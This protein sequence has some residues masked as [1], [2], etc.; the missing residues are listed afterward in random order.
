[1]WSNKYIGI[2]YKQKGRDFDG[3]DCWGLVRLIYKQ[4]YDIS[5]P[6]FVN[7]YAEQDTLRIQDLI[8]Q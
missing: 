8:A 2:P 3:I 5:L 1:M 4:E 6:S 7:D